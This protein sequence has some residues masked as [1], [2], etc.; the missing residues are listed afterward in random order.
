M[1]QSF[2][3]AQVNANE[4][5]YEVQHRWFWEGFFQYMNLSSTIVNA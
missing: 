4:D 5:L 1:I 3:F 2:T